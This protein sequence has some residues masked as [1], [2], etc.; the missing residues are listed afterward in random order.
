MCAGFMGGPPQRE[1][2]AAYRRASPADQI[3][4]LTNPLMMMYGV[5]DAQVPFEMADWFV[6]AQS[7]AGLK[8][9]SHVRL[10][11]GLLDPCPN[12]PRE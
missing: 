9:V 6:L 7:R 12:T 5:A 3:S 8:D 2:A 4:P 1:R 11:E 10:A